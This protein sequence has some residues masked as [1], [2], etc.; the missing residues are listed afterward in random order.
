MTKL[1]YFISQNI[2]KHC[3]SSTLISDMLVNTMSSIIIK[4]YFTI[5]IHIFY[6]VFS[7]Y[8]FLGDETGRFWKEFV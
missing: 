7:N 5:L 2:L 6:C 3:P 1:L 4:P 8:L